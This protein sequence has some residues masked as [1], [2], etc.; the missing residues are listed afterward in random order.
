[1]NGCVNGGLYLSATLALVNK[2]MARWYGARC[3]PVIRGRPSI[4]PGFVWQA[5]RDA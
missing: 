4:D 1:M 3:I 5:S 2:G